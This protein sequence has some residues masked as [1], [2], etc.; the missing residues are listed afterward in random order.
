MQ[1]DFLVKKIV[2]VQAR[3]ESERLPGKSLM[4]LNGRALVSLVLE[5]AA[6]IQ[7]VERVILA[8][9]DRP[10][11]GELAR[12][13]LNAHGSSIEVFRGPS[14]DVQLRTLEAVRPFGKCF[15][16]RVTADDPFKDPNLYSRAF[17]LIQDSGAD[18]VS[19]SSEK[20]PIGMDVEVFTSN[21]LEKSRE[22]YKT[23]Q[24]REHVTIEMFRRREFVRQ[25]LNVPDLAGKFRL[26]IDYEKDLEFAKCVDRE[27][28]GL[29]GDFAYV[30]T[31]AAARSAIG[32]R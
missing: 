24:N 1:E 23:N 28:R 10:K 29:G 2:V 8:T 20:M 15:V 22:L 30:T 25:K 27:I 16:G 26:T 7:G 18:Y 32:T 4:M 5:R 17:E 9:T 6:S 21:A 3:M 12:H 31:L 13:V 14:E 19:I 11:D